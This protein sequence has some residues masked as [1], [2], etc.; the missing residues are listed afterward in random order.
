MQNLPFT[1]G[2]IVL[3][4]LIVG[5]ALVVYAN[6]RGWLGK[7]GPE[8]AKVEGEAKAEW[9]KL[10]QKHA[11]AAVTTATTAATLA[12]AIATLTATNA[13]LTAVVAAPPVQAV[14][15]ASPP[16]KAAVAS[17]PQP[18]GVPVATSDIHFLAQLV[19]ATT[20]TAIRQKADT[21]LAAACT[22]QGLD[23]NTV[24]NQA[25]AGSASG[26]F[27][28]PQQLRVVDLMVDGVPSVLNLPAHPPY[29]ADQANAQVAHWGKHEV[30]TATP[31]W[32]ASFAAFLVRFNA[33]QV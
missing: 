2:E 5:I 19:A 16:L 27:Y 11:D 18:V 7:F 23:P 9:S 24:R 3:F 25:G 17:Q 13:Q 14:I 32:V 30:V 22:A 4:W 6:K 28:D 33:G 20:N 31:E 10:F 8:I 1:P 12:P 21:S 29:T 15:N 26:S